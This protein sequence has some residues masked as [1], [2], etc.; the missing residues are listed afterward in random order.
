M[1]LNIS[2]RLV[3]LKCIFG[4]NEMQIWWYWNAKL[5]KL[6]CIIGDKEL[7]L[8]PEKYSR[9]SRFIWK[10]LMIPPDSNREIEWYKIKRGHNSSQLLFVVHN[11]V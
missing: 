8:L 7:L 2:A 4:N 3:V 1:S 9:G 11:R 10:E 5:G 6:K